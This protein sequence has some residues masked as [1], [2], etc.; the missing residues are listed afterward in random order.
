MYVFIYV[1]LYAYYCWCIINVLPVIS[2][3]HLLQAA[4]PYFKEYQVQVIKNSQA[5][6]SALQRYGFNIVSGGT[7]THLC[8]V[9]LRPKVCL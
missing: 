5:L 4:T 1:T 8:V 3:T 7:D 6:A 9:D 2:P